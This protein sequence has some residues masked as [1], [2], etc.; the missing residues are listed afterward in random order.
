M[1]RHKPISRDI[2]GDISDLYSVVV[3]LALLG[4]PAPHSR[5]PNLGQPVAGPCRLI[6]G[7]TNG[8]LA[9]ADDITL[10]IS[11]CLGFDNILQLCA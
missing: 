6:D 4:G 9:L 8:L 5:E 2:S 3:G 11:Q 10:A 1:A 7:A